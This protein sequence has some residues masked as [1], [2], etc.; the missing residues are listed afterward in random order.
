MMSKV[1]DI[2]RLC[3]FWL[4]FSLDPESWV[5]D[6]LDLGLRS[7]ANNDYFQYESSSTSF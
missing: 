7:C 4:S 2:T 3:L 6:E 5:F 1:I